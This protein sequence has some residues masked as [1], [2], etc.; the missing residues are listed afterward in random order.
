MPKNKK[1]EALKAAAL[2]AVQELHA[3][4]SVGNLVTREDLVELRDEIS[5]L[6]YGIDADIARG[7]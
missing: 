6:I 7:R 4:T 3:D 5:E 2:E 1:H